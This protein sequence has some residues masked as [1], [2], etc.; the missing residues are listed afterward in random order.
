MHELPSL[1]EEKQCNVDTNLSVKPLEKYWNR[2]FNKFIDFKS[3]INRK[4]GGG[5]P[6]KLK[7][8]AEELGKLSK[9]KFLKD[10][11]PYVLYKVCFGQ[12]IHSKLTN[13][14][15]FGHGT[16]SLRIDRK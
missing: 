10:D 8:K 4:I 1:I 11:H 13:S 15:I 5:M 14:E 12:N 2:M 3:D 9:F 16:T 6:K 7:D